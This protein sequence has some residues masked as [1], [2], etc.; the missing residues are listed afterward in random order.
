MKLTK[1]NVWNT[2]SFMDIKIGYYKAV[3]KKENTVEL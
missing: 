2:H 3:N 1:E